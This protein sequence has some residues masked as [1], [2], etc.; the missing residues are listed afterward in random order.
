Q[1]HFTNSAPAIA[2]LDGDGHNDLIVLSSVQNAA[3]S[4][5]ERGVALWAFRP[6]GTR[7][8]GWTSPLHIPAY[9]GGLWDF[10][11]TNVVGAT[12]QVAIADLTPESEGREVL[13]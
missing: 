10:E 6:D 1:A 8:E 2:D 7:L 5:R 13:F 11:D 9:L 3:Q 12:N 4:D